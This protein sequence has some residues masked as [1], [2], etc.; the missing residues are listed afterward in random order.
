MPKVDVRD[1]VELGNDVRSD[2]VDAAKGKEGQSRDK[3][4]EILAPAPAV[5]EVISSA[6]SADRIWPE[7]IEPS[8]NV[9][10]D[11]SRAKVLFGEA[12]GRA[13]NHEYNKG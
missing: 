8:E 2:L 10:V 3:E 7:F 6:G 9:R 4:E 12:E 11:G 13:A 1:S 5:T